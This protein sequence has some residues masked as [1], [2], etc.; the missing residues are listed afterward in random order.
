[1]FLIKLLRTRV[2][3]E[4]YHWHWDVLAERTLDEGDL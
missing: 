3:D 2:G 1:M 4:E